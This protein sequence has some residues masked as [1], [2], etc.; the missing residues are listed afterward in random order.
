MSEACC[1]HTLE[2]LALRILNGLHRKEPCELI[3]RDLVPA[4]KFVGEE[5][6][7]LGESEKIKE[8][9]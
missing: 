9:S 2:S 1:R 7:N 4:L 8:H 6:A 5:V 3:Y